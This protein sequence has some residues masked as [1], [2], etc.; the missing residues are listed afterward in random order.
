MWGSK[1]YEIKSGNGFRNSE[2]DSGEIPDFSMKRVG[3]RKVLFFHVV[4][5][6]FSIFCFCLLVEIFF[7]GIIDYDIII[8]AKSNAARRKNVLS[9]VADMAKSIVFIS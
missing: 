2:T 8:Y 1:S 7:S 3:A 6:F 9:S 4:N 5:S